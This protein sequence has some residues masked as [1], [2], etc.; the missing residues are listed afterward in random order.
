M[1]KDIYDGTG[2]EGRLVDITVKYGDFSAIGMIIISILS[3]VIVIFS[4]A[5]YFPIIKAIINLF[6]PSKVARK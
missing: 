3:F 4:L 6:K 2:P 5:L 1:E